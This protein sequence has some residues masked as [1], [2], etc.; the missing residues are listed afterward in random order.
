[1]LYY[2]LCQ[3]VFTLF[4]GWMHILLYNLLIA[5]MGNTYHLVLEEIDI[6]YKKSVKF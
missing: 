5:M 1:M 2:S 3:T 4:L 6:E